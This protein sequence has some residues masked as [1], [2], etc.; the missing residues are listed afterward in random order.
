MSEETV[1][2][3]TAEPTTS[4]PV[5]QTETP[6][7]E[8]ETATDAAVEA[9]GAEEVPTPSDE[10]RKFLVKVDGEE[11]EVSEDELLK[12]YS[13]GKASA[14]RF[15]EAAKV[16]KQ[17]ER[18]IEALKDPEQLPELLGKLGVDFNGVVERKIKELIEEESLPE[19]ER[20][21]R[22]LA[23]ER[24]RLEREKQEWEQA[25][26]QTKL[27]RETEA[28]R[29]RLVTEF[30]DAAETSGIPHT[31]RTIAMMA[32]AMEGALLAGEELSAQEAAEIV[33]EDL[34][35]TMR[36]RLGNLDAESLA[37]LLGEDK[38]KALRARDVEKLKAVEKPSPTKKSSFRKPKPK[39]QKPIGTVDAFRAFLNGEE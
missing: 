32:Q 6:S 3:E 36:D 19:G 11:V 23:K 39:A 26:N 35:T 10:P 15:E 13:R 4:E 1:V 25:Q 33:K 27:Q 34:E 12:G 29:Q 22:A 7:T 17:T 24:E 37:A 31:P 9:A 18:L 20:E 2:T 38:L 28:E 21:K 5:T 8:A 30:K 16:R 14:K